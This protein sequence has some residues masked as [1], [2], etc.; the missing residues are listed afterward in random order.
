[1]MPF[2]ASV[3]LQWGAPLLQ[4]PSPKSDAW[5]WVVQ[6]IELLAF[7]APHFVVACMLA[8]YS[9]TQSVTIACAP[10]LGCYP[11]AVFDLKKI[12]LQICGPPTK[13]KKYSGPCG[14]AQICCAI[15]NG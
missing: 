4:K 5:Q 7:D 11:F 13:D 10:C 9:V 1:M 8:C 12:G 14:I 2:T 3:C 15:C 6:Q